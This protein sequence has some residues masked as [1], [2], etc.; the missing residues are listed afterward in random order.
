MGSDSPRRIALS[1]AGFTTAGLAGVA[2]ALMIAAALGAD[3]TTAASH[4]IVKEAP[5]TDTAPP[6]SSTTSTEPPTTTSSSTTTLEPEPP[7]PLEIDLACREQEVT[8]VQPELSSE[9]IN[10]VSTTANS[11][12]P[13]RVSTTTTDDIAP[14]PEPFTE[15]PDALCDQL[16]LGEV[17]LSMEPEATTNIDG[18][19][20]PTTH[21]G[22]P[23]EIE[24]DI[25]EWIDEKMQR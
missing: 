10:A 13:S 16:E 12:A 3:A 22:S 24:T 9:P 2:V 1:I 18:A 25:N 21:P 17:A 8:A 11:T 14:V 23:P 6:T 5:T 20:P 7:P 15:L 19:W 4:P